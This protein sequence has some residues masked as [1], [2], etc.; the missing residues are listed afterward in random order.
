MGSAGSIDEV[1]TESNPHFKQSGTTKFMTTSILLDVWRCA[2]DKGDGFE[3]V[4]VPKECE[5]TALGRPEPVK[6]Q[7]RHSVIL[8][9]DGKD[10]FEQICQNL[11][12][13]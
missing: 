4:I 13:K 1:T 9:Y 10:S 7:A 8:K 3:L 2:S 5:L 6:L 11:L 12:S